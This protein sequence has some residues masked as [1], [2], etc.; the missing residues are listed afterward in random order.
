MARSKPDLIYWRDDLFTRFH[1]ET[2]AGE[3]AWRAIAAKCDGT[4]AVFHH[5]EASTLRRLRAAG[6]S[7]A[8]RRAVPVGDMTDDE[9]LHEL[10]C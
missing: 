9:L 4:A 3:D 6:F 5:Q 8:F 1:P 2:K 10:E 7:A